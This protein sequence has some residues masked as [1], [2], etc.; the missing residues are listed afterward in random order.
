MKPIVRVCTGAVLG[1]AAMMATLAGCVSDRPALRATVIVHVAEPAHVPVFVTERAPFDGRELLENG[2]FEAPS[3]APGTWNVFTSI[4]GWQRASGPGVEVQNHV[5]GSPFEGAQHIELDSHAPSAI[6]QDVQTEPGAL[7]ELRLWYSPRPGTLPTDSRIVVRFGAQ[8]V[9]QLEGSGEQLND[10]D[11][12][13]YRFH[14][15][16]TESSTRL[17]LR[18]AGTPNSLGA[19]LDGLSLRRIE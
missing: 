11:W 18:D 8:L 5:A 6:A 7:Y 15:R 9:A 19:Y 13:P 3:L 14:L 17:E 2:G 12:R 1:L 10:T 4:A 16:A